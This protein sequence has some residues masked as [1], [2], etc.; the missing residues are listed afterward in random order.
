MKNG[1]RIVQRRYT[2]GHEAPPRQSWRDRDGRDRDTSAPRI[3]KQKATSDVAAK[4]D[5][6]E[7]VFQ[8]ESLNGSWARGGAE[9]VVGGLEKAG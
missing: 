3:T 5:F 6:C 9:H 8:S 2:C 1:R 4:F 7:E